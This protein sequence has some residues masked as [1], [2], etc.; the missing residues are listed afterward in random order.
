LTGYRKEGNKAE[1]TRPGDEPGLAVRPINE[2]DAMNSWKL[3]CRYFLGDR[4]CK[5]KR[6][7]EGCDRY[8][9]L[10]T[11]ILIIKLGAIGDVLRTTP[12]L[13]GLKRTY[14]LS[15]LTWVTAKESLPLLKNNP[16]IDRLLPF[17]FPSLLPLEEEF[18]DLVIGLEKEPPGAALTSKVRAGDKKG[19]GLN[20]E[21]RVFPLNRGSE[22]AF[23]LGL[24]DELKFHRNQQTYPELIFQAAE[25][26]YQRD[27]YIL[28]QAEADLAFAQA[29]AKKKGLRKGER[30][31][32]LNTGAGD[33]FANKAWTVEGYL[34]LIAALKKETKTRLLLLGGPKERECNLEIRKKAKGAVID[35][36]GENSLGE[37]AALIDLC[38]L[39]VTGDTT[40]LHVA[41]ALKKK[42]VAL[43]GPTCAQEIDL[44]GRGEKIVTPLSCAP[45]YKRGC[46]LVP[47]CMEAIGVEAV[48]QKVKTLLPARPR[49]GRV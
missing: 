14:P 43:F 33:V 2:P 44:Y 28:F 6:F 41:I 18:F 49:A 37:F 7:C 10:G 13:S 38:D 8:Q 45:C 27:E 31:I 16:L 5:F 22:Y 42:V 48:L 46:S 20:P 21:G 3:N 1:G 36:G 35:T 4:P 24:S 23:L 17:D 40:A 11:R 30:V 9:P 26:D 47:H 29:W 19:F 34:G 25:L 39:V 15:Y 12:L 32:G